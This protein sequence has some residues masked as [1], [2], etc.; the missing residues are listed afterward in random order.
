MGASIGRV[1]VGASDLLLAHRRG[2]CH[3]FVRA[4]LTICLL[5][6]A[7]SSYFSSAKLSYSPI[8]TRQT[9]PIMPSSKLLHLIMVSLLVQAKPLPST[10][11]EGVNPY[12]NPEEIVP[13]QLSFLHNERSQN[14]VSWGTYIPD[15]IKRDDKAYHSKCDDK[16]NCEIVDDDAPEERAILHERKFGQGGSPNTPSREQ[17][18]RLNLKNIPV[19][20]ECKP[21]SSNRQ[22]CTNIPCETVSSRLQNNTGEGNLRCLRCD[23]LHNCLHMDCQAVQATFYS[24]KKQPNATTTS[25]DAQAGTRVD[26]R[27]N[28]SQV[29]VWVCNVCEYPGIN[30][31]PCSSQQA[32]ARSLPKSD[33]QGSAKDRRQ[34][35]LDLPWYE[36]LILPLKHKN[37]TMKTPN[38]RSGVADVSGLYGSRV[39]GRSD[40]PE[41]SQYED[42]L[43]VHEICIAGR[44]YS[45][46]TF[47]NVDCATATKIYQNRYFNQN[48]GQVLMEEQ[49]RRDLEPAFAD[50]PLLYPRESDIS[51]D[52]DT[53]VLYHAPSGLTNEDSNDDGATALNIRSGT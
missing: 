25:D 18:E 30:C 11:P 40:D 44:R 8:T 26:T 24:D 32:K 49:R 46:G 53:P 39:H 47:Q 27:S 36:F 3:H 31:E 45:T 6:A 13:R 41:R 21:V 4:F 15:Q 33:E 10:P 7:S 37:T 16:G 2:I 52:D 42:S 17:I 1:A 35:D 19:C 34:R 22:S 20:Y 9:T 12:P 28:D 23:Q 51:N 43:Q 50:H 48:D 38:K 29:I 5:N 14:S